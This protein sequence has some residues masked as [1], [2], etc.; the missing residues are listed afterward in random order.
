MVIGKGI[1]VMSVLSSLI[2]A[3]HIHHAT[4]MKHHEVKSIPTTTTT[5]VSASKMNEWASVAWCETHGNW[6]HQG[7]RYEGGLGIMP[8]NWIYYGGEEFAPHAWQATPE[9]QVVVAMRIQDGLPTPDR[10]GECHAW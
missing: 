9:Q 3:P 10:N 1:A 6:K 4:V 8:I 7:S 5:L 2:I